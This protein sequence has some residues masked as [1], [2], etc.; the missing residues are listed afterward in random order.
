MLT[1]VHHEW[2]S[3]TR[4]TCQLS[5][6]L[7]GTSQSPSTD[8]LLAELPANQPKGPQQQQPCWQWQRH[9]QLPLLLPG[10]GLSLFWTWG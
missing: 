1:L 8:V 9:H 10:H 6:N 3:G 2:C 4:Y 5:A 7:I